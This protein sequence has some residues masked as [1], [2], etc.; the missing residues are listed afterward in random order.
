MNEKLISAV[1]VYVL[2]M[3]STGFMVHVLIIP[4]LLST[5]FRDS[6]LSVL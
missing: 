3:M 5:S 4:I 1:H 6:W 2:M